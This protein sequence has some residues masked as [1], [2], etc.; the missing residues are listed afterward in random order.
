MREILN[1]I[2]IKPTNENTEYIQS[3]YTVCVFY[4]DG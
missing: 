4:M 3:L 2:R 1:Q